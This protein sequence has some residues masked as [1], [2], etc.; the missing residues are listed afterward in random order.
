M[1]SE[2]PIA[3]AFK[4]D[5]ADFDNAKVVPGEGISANITGIEYRMGTVYF[6]QL[7]EDLQDNADVYLVKFPKEENVSELVASFNLKDATRPGLRALFNNLSKD[8]IQILS[9]DRREKVKSIADSLGV[10]WY[11]SGLKPS[12]K[13]EHIAKLQSREKSY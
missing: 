13:Q 4:K 6:C 9:G 5:F 12:D 7:S 8:D 3:S 11:Q 1:H 2:H 10:S